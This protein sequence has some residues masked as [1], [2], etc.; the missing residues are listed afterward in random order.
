VRVAEWFR[1]PGPLAPE[2]AA[3]LYAE[4]AVRMVKPPAGAAARKP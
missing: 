4:M 2:E 3:Q 1:N